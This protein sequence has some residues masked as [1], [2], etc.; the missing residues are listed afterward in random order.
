MNRIRDNIWLGSRADAENHALLRRNGITAVL[1]VAIDLNDP[2]CDDIGWFKVGLIDGP[3]NPRHR[4][5]M[6]IQTLYELLRAEEVVYVHCI[7]GRSRS[8]Y[9]VARCL[10]CIERRTFD[11]IWAE[12]R[13][14]RPKVMEKSLLLGAY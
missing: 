6:A 4:V 10:E 13:R 5:V 1:N 11:E 12:L 3:G 7:A 9:V 8:A 2:H 14:L